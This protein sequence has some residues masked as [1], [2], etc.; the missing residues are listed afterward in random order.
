MACGIL[1]PRP[2]MEPGPSAVKAPTPNHWTTRELP[3]NFFLFNSWK[4]P[5]WLPNPSGKLTRSVDLPLRNTQLGIKFLGLPI[6]SENHPLSPGWTVQGKNRGSENQES[7]HPSSVILGGERGVAQGPGVGAEDAP[8]PVLELV[9][10][11][12]S[13]F[14][15]PWMEL[16]TFVHDLYT[17]GVCYLHKKQN[18]KTKYFNIQP[19]RKRFGRR[20]S[21]ALT[22]ARISTK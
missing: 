10:H 16:Y 4:A 15:K 5:S 13:L 20:F 8:L 21:R 1:V 7:S 3:N 19:I 18:S 9:T 6:T 22:M 17:N 12:C 2:G 14:K 11:G